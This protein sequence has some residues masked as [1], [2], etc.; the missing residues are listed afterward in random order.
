M[1]FSLTNLTA[2]TAE[3]GQSML[4][5]YVS[6]RIVSS[7]GYILFAF[8]GFM[9][10][11]ML[12]DII[13]ALSPFGSSFEMLST[14]STFKN[15]DVWEGPDPGIQIERGLAWVNYFFIPL[16]SLFAG[17]VSCWISPRGKEV[18]CA[19]IAIIVAMIILHALDLATLRPIDTVDIIRDSLCIMIAVVTSTLV[20]RVKQSR[21]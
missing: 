7:I 16:A 17:I 5:G 1:A 19:V 2:G 12:I 4:K 6:K 15:L 13:F 10:I 8:C 3:E 9:G 14:L 21:W 18:W 20:R 11:S